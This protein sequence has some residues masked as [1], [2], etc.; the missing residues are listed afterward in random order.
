MSNE[1]TAI[2]S[3]AIKMGV[4]ANLVMAISGWVAFHYSGSQAVLLDGNMSFVLFL[5]SIVA[6]KIAKIKSEKS[7]RFPF[8]L[9]A[10]EALYSFMKGVLLIG[11]LVSAFTTNIGRV[12]QYANGEPL[13]AIQTGPIVIYSTAMV[14]ICFC[15]SWFY[16]LQNKRIKMASPLLKVDQKAAMIDGLLSGSTGLVLVIT[17]FIPEGTSLEFLHYIGDAI[18]V[19]VLATFVIFQPIS[20]LKEA[21]VELAAGRL[22]DKEKHATI[23]SKAKEKLRK[24]G[25]EGKKINISKTGSS[26]L[27]LIEM[28]VSALQSKD[29]KVFSGLTLELEQELEM[30]FPY[31]YVELILS[32]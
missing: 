10:S 14:S 4:F 7:E 17:G 2:E 13:N 30:D 19:C 3:Q 31:V 8:G 25:L 26:Y 6:F 24:F 20:V 11:I 18:L 22:R 21:F 16:L 5:S 23:E 15:L 12:L 27:V 1:V 32:N 9:Y 28:P 29:A